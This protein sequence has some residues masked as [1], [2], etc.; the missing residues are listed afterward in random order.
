MIEVK[1]S[2]HFIDK[3]FEVL[4]NIYSTTQY[5]KLLYQVGFKTIF[6]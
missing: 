2:T 4:L 5:Q 6:N 1:M 3:I